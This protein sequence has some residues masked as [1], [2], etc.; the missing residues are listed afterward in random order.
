MK[1]LL[2]FIVM[3]LAL[4]MTGY[5]FAGAEATGSPIDGLCF[6]SSLDADTGAAPAIAMTMEKGDTLFIGAPGDSPAIAVNEIYTDAY[7]DGYGETGAGHS[8]GGHSHSEGGAPLCGCTIA[9]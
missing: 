8:T 3:L 7:T 1:K 6:I 9:L 5:A 4:G 2:C